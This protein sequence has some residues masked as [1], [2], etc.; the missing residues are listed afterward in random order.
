VICGGGMA[1]LTLALQ[2][3]R[4]QPARTVTVIE[5]QTRP[6]P[7]ACHKV[8]ESTV[9]LGS[10]YLASTLGLGDYLRR[11]HLLKNGLRYFVGD[12]RGPVHAR[13]EIG[14]PELPTI[15]S[16]QIERGRF[17]THLRARC[18]AEGVDLR[19][20]FRARDVTLGDD[21]EHLVTIARESAQDDTR[22]HAPE[23]ATITL[24]ARWL[25]DA[26][27]RRGLL[28][29]KLGLREDSPHKASAVWFRVGERVDIAE[30]VDRDAHA[31]W[32]ARDPDHI[33]YLSTVH[34]MGAGYW[35]WIIPLAS[36]ATSIGIVTDETMHPMR[37]YSQPERARAWL[38]T[39]EPA[40]ATR[41]ADVPFED[42]LGLRDYSYLSNQ[43]MS[44]ARWAC[45]GEA[46]L[47][48]D[49][50]YSPG[51]DFLA[52]SNCYTAQLIKEDFAGQW[53]PARVRAMNDFFVQAAQVF[54]LNYA[55][56]YPLFAR[57]RVIAAKIFW[58]N[59]VYWAFVCQHF[60]QDLHQHPEGFGAEVSE[61]AQ[62]YLMLNTKV[63][64]LLAR[65]GAFAATTWTRPAVTLPQIPSYLASLHRDLG[66]EKSLQQTI[67]DMRTNLHH[68]REF[69]R[70]IFLR[71]VYDAGPEHIE[72]LRPVEY[73]AW[74]LPVD[75]ERFAPTEQKQSR[76]ARLDAMP[77]CAREFERC[78]GRLR[79]EDA[80]P[81]MRELLTR[82]CG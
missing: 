52:M 12:A 73:A 37:D 32:H 71:A 72:A 60:F 70:E 69:A 33:R 1:G 38:R 54:L 18:E 63:Q 51:A 67:T 65:W 24:R 31:D 10:H 62:E 55:G 81:S 2:L 11:E 50:F 44:S 27:G 79:Y 82:A 45:V 7:G 5:P 46:A 30:L 56:K 22:E 80:T 78:Y 43:V 64:L 76:R 25:I 57:P 61:L 49:P 9:E 8:G 21:S 16:F 77:P 28:Q 6:L 14:P 53:R 4:E 42:F 59:L 3:R 26:T 74:G 23:H 35:V 36:G 17:E 15:P 58:D 41:I 39:H 48:V 68:A 47:F 29:R 75:L 34:L 13:T 66:R 20:G 19:E 40:I